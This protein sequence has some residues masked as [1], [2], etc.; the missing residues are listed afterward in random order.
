MGAVVFPREG[1]LEAALVEEAP[2]AYRDVREVLRQQ[3]D[4]V[5]LVLRLEPRA[6][7]KGV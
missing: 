1:P 7:L 5:R 4:L 6:V 2:S 3:S